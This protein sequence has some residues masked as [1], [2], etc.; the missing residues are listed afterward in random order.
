[1]QHKESTEAKKLT[2]TNTA[3]ARKKKE[4]HKLGPGG[5]KKAIPKWDRNEQDIMATGIIPATLDWPE[6]AK[7][8]YFAHGGK[9]NPED[10][11]L[12]PGDQLRETAARLV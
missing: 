9:L 5:Y 2:E 8:Y 11:T 12:L 6:R 10:G 3:N 7:Y 1:M 4:F